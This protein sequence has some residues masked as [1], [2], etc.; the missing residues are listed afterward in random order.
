MKTIRDLEAKSHAEKLKKPRTFSLKNQEYNCI[1]EST[2]ACFPIIP[3]IP[4][5]KYTK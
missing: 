1:F 4:S 5:Q 3:T 2:Q